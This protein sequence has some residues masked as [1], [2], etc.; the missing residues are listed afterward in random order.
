MNMFL[1]FCKSYRL[2]ASVWG[3][4]TEHL[5]GYDEKYDINSI[6]QALYVF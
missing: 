1:Y 6:R 5:E 4:T 3:Q 2:H